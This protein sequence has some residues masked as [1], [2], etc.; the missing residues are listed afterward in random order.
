MAGSIADPEALVV[1]LGSNSFQDREAASLAL[2]KM[3]D[4]ALPALRKA[5]SSDDPE[6][7]QRATAILKGDQHFSRRPVVEDFQGH[8]IGRGLF[9]GKCESLLF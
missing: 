7:A 1:S 6:V 9:H 2:R 5:A 3:G 8:A 4:P